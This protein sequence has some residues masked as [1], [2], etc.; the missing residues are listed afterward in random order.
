MF[1]KYK[2]MFEKIAEV[3]GKQVSPLDAYGSKLKSKKVNITLRSGVEQN[4]IEFNQGGRIAGIELG[5]GSDL[6]QA[7]RKVML[8]ARWDNE[9]NSALDLPLHDFFGFAFGKPAMQSILLGSNN[10]KLYSYLP[11][12][13]DQSATLKMKYDKIAANDP[14]E[15]LISGTIYYTEDKRDEKSEGK[16]YAQSRRVYNGAQAVP[17]TIADVKGKGHFVGTILIAKGLED[18]H[19]LFFE[20]DDIATIDGKM[21]LHGT[22]SED[23][24]NGGYY[25]ILDKWDARVSL[26]IHGSLGYNQMTSRTGGFRFYL[27]DKLNFEKSFNLTIEHQPEDA[28]NVKTDYTSVGLFYAEKPQFENTEIRIDDKVT[29]IPHRDKLTPQ[30]MV[31]SLYWLATADYQ[32]PAIVF[33]LKKSDG[34]FTTVDME[35][36]PVVQV[37]LSGLDNGRYKLYIEYGRTE[38][39]GPFSV[40]QRLK[41]VSDWIPTEIE[42]TPANE[43]KIVYAGDIEIT[44][45]LKTITLRKKKTDDSIIRIYKFLFEKTDVPE[46]SNKNKK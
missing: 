14:D 8:T 33:G 20:G 30:G 43:G 11:M 23:Y 6:L 36:I 25:A 17:H 4:M 22:G 42:E 7:Y 16:F 40:W 10:Q 18:G 37:S 41:Q 38:N 39:S 5:A 9:A 3:W 26:P 19:T 45:E 31:F 35:A 46:Q 28:Q 27:T 29:K 32:D 21:K 24:F 15:I 12:P 13:F 1:H 2:E 34:W 44:E